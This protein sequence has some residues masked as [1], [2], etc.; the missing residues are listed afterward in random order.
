M[1]SLVFRKKEG[2]VESDKDPQHNKYFFYPMSLIM[3]K[4]EQ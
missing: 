2:Q 1:F 4:M 3:E